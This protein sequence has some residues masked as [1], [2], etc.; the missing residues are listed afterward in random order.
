V[1][2][3]VRR[4][5]TEQRLMYELVSRMAPA[6]LIALIGIVGGLFVG[7]VVFVTGIVMGFRLEI[8]RAEMAIAF[9]R[10]LLERGLTPDEIGIVVEAGSKNSKRLCKSLADAEV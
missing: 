6:E 2:I 5:K 1:V 10:E 7:L 4:Y 9:K 8:R 3:A